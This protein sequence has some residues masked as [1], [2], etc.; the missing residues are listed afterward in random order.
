M[1]DPNYAFTARQLLLGALPPGTYE[2]LP[3]GMLALGEE[4][5]WL[6]LWSPEELGDPE[7][8]IKELQERARSEG[9][10]WAG[11][12]LLQPVEAGESAG[13]N[14]LAEALYV[15]GLPELQGHPGL[16]MLPG[17]STPVKPVKGL[18]LAAEDEET[19]P[20]AEA[21]F[22]AALS[23][24][25]PL[26]SPLLDVQRLLESQRL[27]VLIDERPV[28]L[29]QLSRGGLLGRI[30]LIWV[31]PAARSHGVGR[32]VMHE[33]AQYAQQQGL[34]MLSV[35]VQREGMLRYFLAKSGYQEQI[36]VRLYVGE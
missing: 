27:V 32:A 2:D 35:W 8:K 23:E 10:R 34:L 7:P 33:V 26:T 13:L 6:G 21:F 9:K 15:Y 11:V 5:F 24:G 19:R 22:S 4:E 25:E 17:K 16:V 14:Y 1:P 29:I 30:N 36:R 3:G 12:I 20:A 31:D 18:R 28:G